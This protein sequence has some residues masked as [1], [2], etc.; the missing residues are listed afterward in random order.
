MFRKLVIGL[1]SFIFSS[2]L[3]LLFIS[4]SLLTIARPAN[5]KGWL[6]ES[7]LYQSLPD[8]ILN[9]AQASATD[10][11]VSLANPIIQAAAKVALT[12]ALMQTIGEKVVDGA[13][14]W[15]D[16]D[17][18]QPDFSVDLN[19]TK[20]A[21]ADRATTLIRERYDALP[22]CGRKL[23]ASTDPLTID[24]KPL[25]SFDID[26][27]LANLRTQIVS[28]KDF[29]PDS[30]LNAQTLTTEEN[31]VQKPI[32]ERYKQVPEQ[33]ALLQKLPLISLFIAVVMAVAIIFASKTKIYGLRK[34][35]ITL[36][37]S[38]LLAAGGLWASSY[39]TNNIKSQLSQPGQAQDYSAYIINI[40]NAA[41]NDFVATGIKIAVAYGVL[42]G[43][44]IIGVYICERRRKPAPSITTDIPTVQ[45]Q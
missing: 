1:A 18:P 11:T 34:I 7:G 45:P 35:G 3:V 36:L 12:P 26:T 20:V 8:T 39:I 42:G 23:P 31:G 29:L 5:I 13:F 9:N 25:I 22:S 37:I 14:T 2:V 44:L 27:Q 41:R 4:L 38:G 19:P 16:G 33:Y 21:F 30:V 24:C 40:A 43:L 6:S 28:S 15:L 17:A 10:S 32:F